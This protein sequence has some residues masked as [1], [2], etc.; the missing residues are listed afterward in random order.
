MEEKHESGTF[1]PG[2]QH[3][4]NR[5]FQEGSD[6]KT[7]GTIVALAFTLAGSLAQIEA[8]EKGCGV[9]R[10]AASDPND[11]RSKPQGSPEKS[12]DQKKA[13]PKPEA[14]ACF[15]SLCLGCGDFGCGRG[16][17]RRGCWDCGCSG[18]WPSDYNCCRPWH[19]SACYDVCTQNNVYEVSSWCS[20]MPDLGPIP[21]PAKT[22]RIV[23]PLK[24]RTTLSFKVNGQAYLLEAGKT[25]ELALTGDTVIEFDRVAESKS[26]R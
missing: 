20:V 25:Q 1:S 13:C 10:N 19:S 8:S 2:V 18:C 7:I 26:S 21:A 9:Y 3:Q 5:H 4:N 23:N 17:D 16:W 12:A 11:P 6:M 22:V 15:D 14:G 24:T